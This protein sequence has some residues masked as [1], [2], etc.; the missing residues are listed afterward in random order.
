MLLRRLS[1]LAGALITA[2]LVAAPAALAHTTLQSS[3]PAEGAALSAAPSQVSL[4][5]GGSFTLPAEP[6]RITGP[7]G[8][9]WTVGPATV[10]DRTLTAPVQPSGPAGAYVL[11][12][13]IVAADGDPITG[14]INFS[15]TAPASTPSPSAAPSS[16]PVPP[17]TQ[18][19]QAAEPSGGGFPVWAWVVIA[20]VVAAAIAGTVAVIVRGRRSAS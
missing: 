6:I 3:D 7:E 15:L 11:T 14:R 19:P 2:L 8:A 12:W 17:A 20:V 16:A 10:T 9:Q 1:V 18:A 5:F 4:K 13:S